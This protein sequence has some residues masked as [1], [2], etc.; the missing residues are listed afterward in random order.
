[1][2]KKYSKNNDTTYLT[3]E[4]RPVMN[5]EKD[6]VI[7]MMK[8]FKFYLREVSISTKKSIFFPHTEFDWI[9]RDYRN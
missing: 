7:I 1:M 3:I 4:Q 2:K 6:Q 8:S 9:P 5:H